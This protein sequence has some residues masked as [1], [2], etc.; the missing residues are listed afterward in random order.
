MSTSIIQV[1]QLN[2]VRKQEKKEDKFSSLGLFCSAIVL[3][4]YVA[5]LETVSSCM[6]T[7]WLSHHH[8]V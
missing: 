4:E 3:L 8:R 2:I 6:L 1:T 7:Y 5:V